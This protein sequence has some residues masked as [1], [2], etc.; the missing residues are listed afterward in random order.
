MSYIGVTMLIF[1]VVIFIGGTD[2]AEKKATSPNQYGQVVGNIQVTIPDGTKKEFRV[3][4][5]V[6]PQYQEVL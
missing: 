3:F 1:L 5:Q 6:S 4:D 2:A